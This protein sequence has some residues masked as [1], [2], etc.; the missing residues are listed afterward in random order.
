VAIYGSTPLFALPTAEYSGIPGQGDQEHAS[1]HD[2]G[3]VATVHLDCYFEFLSQV[4]LD[5]LVTPLLRSF[6]TSD[7]GIDE[8]PET[9]TKETFSALGPA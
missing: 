7:S 9:T 2:C 6:K 1:I 8:S 5:A 4:D 3:I